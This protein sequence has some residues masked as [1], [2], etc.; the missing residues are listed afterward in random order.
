M[1]VL[2]EIIE[3]LLSALF[4]IGRML[5]MQTTGERDGKYRAR[6]GRESLLLS[7]WNKGFTLTGI[8]SLSEKLSWQNALIVGS[9][10]TG[11]SANIIIPTIYNLARQGFALVIN[12]PSKELFRVLAWILVNVFGYE[13]RVINPT[14]YLSSSFYNPLH[15][16]SAFADL[17]RVASQIVRTSLGAKSSD[18]FWNTSATSVLAMFMGIL[19]TQDREYLNM[20][21]VRSLLL[22]ASSDSASLDPLFSRFASQELFEEWMS[23]QAMDVKVKASV[24]STAKASCDLWADEGV[25]HITSRDNINLEELRTSD[26]PIAIFVT[27]NTASMRYYSLLTSLLFEDL[28]GVVMSDLPEQDTRSLYSIIDEASSL[29]IP[30]LPVALSNQRKYKAGSLLAVQEVSQLRDL[31]GDESQAIV[32]N[33][34]SRVYLTGQSI[35]VAQELERTIGKAEFTDVEG[36]IRVRPLMTADELRML[37]TNR[38]LLVAGHHPVIKLKFRPYYKQRRFRKYLNNPPIEMMVHETTPVELLDV[39]ALLSEPEQETDVIETLT[40]IH[41]EEE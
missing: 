23:F 40:P 11:K 22:R 19:L 38:G 12:D 41:D 36:N 29:Y 35:Q 1:K 2:I 7:R 5:L 6:F 30:L 10:G 39:D 27:S 3:Q 16:C 9:T 8:K 21:N 34:Y 25:A 14:E 4:D 32:Q 20:S 24:L 17:R 18:P 31:Y 37:P 33:C 13:V 26:R 15:R 28:Y